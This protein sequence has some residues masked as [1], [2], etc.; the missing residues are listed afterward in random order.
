MFGLG[1]F[2]VSLV[3][4]LIIL[5]SILCVIYGAVNWNKEGDEDATL[6][7]EERQWQAEE[8][9]IEENL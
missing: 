3:F 8:K 9:T 7:D 1:D 6:V 5:S 4:V 2:W